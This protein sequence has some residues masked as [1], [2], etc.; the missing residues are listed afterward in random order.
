MNWKILALAVSLVFV[1]VLVFNIHGSAER[2]ELSPEKIAEWWRF[3]TYMFAHLNLAHLMQNIF[4]IMLAAVIAIELK[5]LFADFS[6]VY[7]GSGIFAVL[8]LWAIMQ[9]TALGASAAVYGV[10]GL[11][12]IEVKKYV[13]PVYI[14]PIFIF[15]I[16]I[17]SAF[18][19]KK[20]FAIEQALSHFSGFAFGMFSFAIISGLKQILG[21]KKISVLRR[22]AG[23]Y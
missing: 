6:S 3:F 14:I 18:T 12:S 11:M 10:Y 7:F 2:F 5:T 15:V 1:Y 21:R 4:G 16:F 22:V 23:S 19:P 9:F 17:E 8:P 13:N 20:G